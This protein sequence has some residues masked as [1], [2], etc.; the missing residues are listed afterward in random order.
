MFCYVFDIDYILEIS[1]W[2]L[3]H[4]SVWLH[5]IFGDILIVFEGQGLCCDAV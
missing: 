1:S 2:Y 4:L 5:K 3:L